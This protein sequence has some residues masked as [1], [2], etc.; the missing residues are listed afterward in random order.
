MGA[1]H[2][3]RML[4]P[5]GKRKALTFSYDDG[6]VHDR[7]LVKM[8]DE[9]GV[10]GTFNLNTRNLGMVE[11][12]EIDGRCVDDSTITAEEISHLFKRHEVA[13]HASKH[14][15]VTA[16]GSAALYEI[17][18]DRKILE[19]IVPYM[20]LGHAYPFG[21]YD[22]DSFAMLKAAGIRYAR[23]VV[24]TG[25]FGLPGN[26]L[27]WHP[28]CHHADGRLMDLAR[29]FCEKDPPYGDPQLFYVWGHS[30]EFDRQDNW[31]I[32][33]NLLSY[34]SGYADQIW[35]ATNME[36]VD[37]VTA[38]Q[39]LVFSADGMKVYNPSVHTVWMESTGEIYQVPSGER[40]VFAATS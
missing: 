2:I 20:V 30:F 6:R 8:M 35:M 4:F 39:N 14:S 3:N 17:L 37:Y 18:E 5:E 12:M 10:K 29:A 23:T 1:F 16:C 13:T 26:F 31:E 27:E 22:Q 25:G 21:I 19:D 15:A 9:A 36:I 7:R 11:T 38:Y 34:L 40:I 24:S 28:T 32:M 33:E